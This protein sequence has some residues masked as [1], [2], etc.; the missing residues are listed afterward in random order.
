[1]YIFKNDNHA[2]SYGL[3]YLFPVSHLLLYLSVVLFRTSLWEERWLSVTPG[4]APLSHKQGETICL[5]SCSPKHRKDS[6]WLS[7]GP[8]LV[9]YQAPYPENAEKA[10][11]RLWLARSRMCGRSSLWRWRSRHCAWQPNHGC[12]ELVGGKLFLMQ[13]PETV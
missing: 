10:Q 12:T 2:T 5:T 7:L 4:L 8:A 6:T 1:M 13:K 3:Q 11:A 9:L